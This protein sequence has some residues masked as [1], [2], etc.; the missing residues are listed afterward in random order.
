MTSASSEAI[1]LSD[2][3]ILFR[4]ACIAIIIQLSVLEI[5]GWRAHWLAH[6]QKTK[7]LDPSQFI[8][9]QMVELPQVAQLT[10]EVPVREGRQEAVISKAIDQGRKASEDEKKHLES[11]DRN[12]TKASPGEAVL[13]PTHGPVAVFAPAPVLPDYLKNQDLNTTVLIEF[14]VTGQGVVTPRLIASSDNEELD[15]LAISTAKRWQFRPAEQDH[16]PV[17]SKVR[18]R[19]VFEVH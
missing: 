17:D 15:A 5:I 11:S 4:C 10:S 14:L 2:F 6:P 12:V 19:I 7:G 9:A 18:L 16:K 3:R 1:P 8:E 13:G